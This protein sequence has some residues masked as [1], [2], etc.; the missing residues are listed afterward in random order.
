M[1]E[2]IRVVAFL[3]SSP[4]QE[5]AVR[6]AALACVE[7]TRAE[8]DNMSYVL[9]EDTQHAGTFVFVEH[10]KSKASLD[11]HMQNSAFQGAVRRPGG[12]AR[13]PDAG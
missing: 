9:H 7:P 1:A 6:D 4:G 10:W 11:R 8:P 12:Q 2:D 13:E 5:T 3:K